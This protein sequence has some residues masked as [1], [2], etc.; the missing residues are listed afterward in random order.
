MPVSLEIPDEVLSALRLPPR[1]IE[2]ELRKVL[3]A[4]RLEILARVPALQPKSIA[5]LA[6]SL[7][8]DFKNV[9]ADVMFFADLGLVE[10]K[11]EG[12]RKTLIPIVRFSGIEVDLGAAA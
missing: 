5:A 9:Y 2:R 4:P 6:R 3:S 8:R 11:A 7:K 1:A 10:L 12:R